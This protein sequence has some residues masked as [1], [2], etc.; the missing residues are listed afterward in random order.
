MRFRLRTSFVGLISVAGVLAVFLL[1]NK[2]NKTEHI[3]LG[4]TADLT[5]PA[6]DSNL[7]TS[8][9]QVGKL[10]DVQIGTVQKAVYKHLNANKEV[11][12]IFGFERLLAE[13]GDQWLL[14]KP[15]MDVFQP[16]FKC[17]ITADSG[18]VQVQ[19]A[20]GGPAPNDGKLVGNV[21][22]R[23]SPTTTTDAGESSIYLDDLVFISE[24]SLLS[25]DG[26]VKFVSKD[27]QML[28]RGLELIYNNQQKQL[29]FLRIKH[30]NT[31]HLKDSKADLFA[32]KIT[33][34]QTAADTPTQKKMQ[35]TNKSLQKTK[36]SLP[37]DTQPSGKNRGKFYKC[38][39][40]KN[41]VIDTDKQMV[42]ADDKL[43]IKN[44]LWAEPTTQSV[45]SADSTANLTAPQRT[46]EEAIP[47]RNKP[48]TASA[49]DTKALA[50]AAS[51][52]NRPKSSTTKLFDAVLTC[53]N[54]FVLIPMD[55]NTS[56]K[57]ALE[58]EDRDSSTGPRPA[59]DFNDTSQ[60]TTLIARQIDYCASTG[61][62]VVTGDSELIFYPNDVIIAENKKSS[63]RKVPVKL[64][65]Q[66]QIRFLPVENQ[67]IFE[68]NCRCTMIRE[69]PNFL[70]TYSLLAPTITVDL[71]RNKPAQS[72]NSTVQ[73]KYL[74]ASGGPVRLAEVKK[75]GQ[76]MLSGFELKSRR[77][78]YDTGLQMFQAAGPGVIKVYNCEVTEPNSKPDTFSFDRPYWAIVQDFATL[79]YFLQTNRI[80]ADAEPQA[81]L[82]ISYIPVL[83]GNYGQPIKASAGHV[84]ALLYDTEH[85]QTGVAIVKATG[86]ITYRHR[87]KQF[88]GSRLFYSHSNF[89]LTVEGDQT[90]PCLLNG[91]LVDGIEY[92]LKTGK[93]KALLVAPGAL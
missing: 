75:A 11:D 28:G 41:V 59:G 90:Q 13:N 53:D 31:L 2:L 67:V 86:A 88:A 71:L 1:Y 15:F 8:G 81:T 9:G 5:R 14:E 30:L 6:T 62:T 54:G 56:I 25:T 84:L 93:V 33:K 40:S 91:T 47:C 44:I 87:D 77:F 18:R 49:N 16:G 22:I 79:K 89:L 42:L 48:E 83:D 68:G 69:D 38:V 92:N 78:N 80:I 27:T 12:R 19:D 43:T 64:T 58:L 85:G 70:R 21:V 4:S 36:A 52:P 10:G 66:R 82:D 37:D 60:R 34:D 46:D 72:P 39:F 24:K 55:S 45:K 3:R 63:P 65:A 50:T 17:S 74:T 76:K 61:S 35:K 73:I 32:P 26:P 7:D 57:D 23:I 20:P 29:E 51:G